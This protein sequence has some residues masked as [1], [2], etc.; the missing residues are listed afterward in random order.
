M[1]IV[2][3]MK[4]AVAAVK[5]TY[6]ASTLHLSGWFAGLT[7]S[8][9]RVG[10]AALARRAYRNPTAGRGLRLVAQLMAAVPFTVVTDDEGTM[11]GSH[12]ML[13][14][15]TRPEPRTGRALLCEKVVAHLYCGGELFFRR[16]APTSGR[17]A[18]KPTATGGSLTLLSPGAFQELVR[19]GGGAVTGY[20]FVTGGTTTTYPADEVLHVRVYD[21]TDEDRGM[22]L[23]LAANRAI[24]QVESAD[25]WNQSVSQGGGRVPGYFVPQLGDGRQLTP[26]QVATAQAQADQATAER[27][28]K[29]LPQVLS[30]MFKYESAAMTMKD[31]DFLKGGEANARRIAAVVGVMY[32]LIG[33]ESSG[34]LTDAG[35]NSYV[36]AAYLLTVLPLLDYVLGE[37]NAWLSPAYGGARL[38]YD[39]DQIEAL[40]EDV[41]GI[42]T[43]YV[44]A[45]GGP[46]LTADEAREANGYAPL[47]GAAAGLR[48]RSTVGA[49]PA[50]GPPAPP[51]EGLPATPPA[52]VDEPPTLRFFRS[53]SEPDVEAVVQRLAA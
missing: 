1:K 42:Y 23:L 13:R 45:S 26:D 7:A 5:A 10:Y 25:A 24:E 12:E 38:A 32:E 16:V 36:R 17:N 39:R 20:R 43:R 48:D 9:G 35:V 2:D 3:A 21:P 37:L 46:F 29:H 8:W 4:N 31:A 40:G 22:P 34:S 53:L 14:L 11:D 30:G 47:G 28:A 41:N 50:G 33:A 15:L 49:V 52:D 19:D 27:R 6:T 51:R 18:G 44:A